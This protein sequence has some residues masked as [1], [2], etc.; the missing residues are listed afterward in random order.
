MFLLNLNI[1][2]KTMALEPITSVKDLLDR[3]HEAEAA[4]ELEHAVELYEQ[5]IKEDAINE[6]SYDRVMIIYRKLKKYKDELRIIN[7]GIKAFE[8]LYKTN[9]KHSK[10]R[11]ILEISNALLKS[12]GLADKKGNHLYDP[13]P[14][15][16]WK[17]RKQ[18][19]ENKIKK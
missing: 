14:I 6:Y 4:Q 1:Y 8:S 2:H 5:A 11:K 19:V 13:E 18:V 10:S 3:A 15:G 17:K 7:A 9:S 12:T 16:K